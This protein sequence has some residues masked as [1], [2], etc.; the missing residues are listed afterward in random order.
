MILRKMQYQELR[1][2]YEDNKN[3]NDSLIKN[4]TVAKRYERMN[5][6]SQI[7]STAEMVF[8]V[9]AMIKKMKYFF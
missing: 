1:Q 6:I 5:V 3:G 9:T 8:T 7:Q 4:K 2:D